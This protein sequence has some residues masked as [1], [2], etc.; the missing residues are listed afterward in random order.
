MAAR[1]A[2]LLGIYAVGRFFVGYVAERR[3]LD[4]GPAAEA[5]SGILAV[6]ALATALASLPAGFL[7]DR[8]RRPVLMGVGGVIAALGMGTLA[9]AGTEPQMLLGG[10][11]MAV[12]SA[13]FGVAN[14]AMLVDLAP[15]PEA[16]RYL[17]LA[18]IG[19][20][21][22]AAAAGL[23]GPLVDAVGFT[24]LFGAAVVASLVAAALAGA[25]H[26]RPIATVQPESL[27]LEGTANE[28]P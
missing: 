25:I 15:A 20:A 24:A 27:R 2:F 6:L 7:S 3:G 11:G 22:A 10:I 16:G 28:R 19:T 9:V 5:A 12:G 1:F 8:F 26:P 14:W 13:L 23:F 17:G 18:N 4:A 21:G